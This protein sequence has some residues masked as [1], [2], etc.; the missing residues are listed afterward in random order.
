[1]ILKI[2][3]NTTFIKEIEIDKP[4]TIETLANSMQEELPYRILCARVNGHRKRLSK[5]IDDDCVVDLLDLRDAWAN[6]VYQSSLS[7]LYIKAVHDVVGKD[8]DVKL[9][10]SLSKGIYTTIHS[11]LVNGNTDQ[12][13]QARMQ[14]LVDARIPF[15]Q[16]RLDREALMYVSKRE[17][18]RWL[19][20]MIEHT[21]DLQVAF[22]SVLDDEKQIFYMYMVPDT[23]Y[24]EH[25]EIKRYKNGMLLRFPHP[26]CPNVVPVYTEQKLLYNAFSEATKW[27]RI[28]G[29]Q[30][31]SNLNE[32]VL[33]E[34]SLRLVLLSEALHEKRI[35]EIAEQINQ[36]NKRI[37]LI[38]GPSSSGKTTFAKR[39]CTQLSVLGKKPLYLGTDDYFKNREETPLGK[40]GK[41]DFECLGAVEVDLFET[42]MNDLLAGKKVDIPQFDFVD[43]VKVFGK[44]ITSIRKNQPIVIEGLHCLNPEL[45]KNIDAKDKF[46]IYISPLTQ[47]NIDPHN[48]IPTTDARM[49]RRIVRDAQF[50]G[51]DAALTISRWAKVRKGEEENIFPFCENAD[52]FFNSHCVYELAVLKKYAEPLLQAITPDQKEYAEAR[53]MLHFLQFFVSLE[54]DTLIPNN[55]IMKEFIGGSVLAKWW[56]NS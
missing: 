29:I 47:L 55:S 18:N 27:D 13:I 25:F 23:S 20:S 36:E 34:D 31:A 54:D 39:L 5:L 9:H 12:L 24:L 21:P 11:N 48:R 7:L 37:I 10:N 3:N 49:L 32:T 51:S 28:T 6:M 43:G 22:Q 53:R 56:F 42:Q 17:N 40:D 19:Y 45:T 2:R 41:P 38:A 15:M 30:Y 1:M 35:A 8:V 16:T 4:M 52:V 50:R 26:S 14:E 33:S 44:R 46:S